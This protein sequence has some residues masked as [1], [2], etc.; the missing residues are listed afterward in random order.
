M[1][2]GL[3]LQ[4]FS[5]ASWKPYKVPGLDTDNLAVE[6]LRSDR[7]DVLWVGSQNRGLI[8]LHAGSWDHFGSEQGLSSDDVEDVFVDR[9]G[10]LWATTTKG[11][12]ASATSR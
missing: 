5:D 1:G 7:D 4:Q 8:R 12:T 11:I 2:P 3:G 6:A 9:E 10:N